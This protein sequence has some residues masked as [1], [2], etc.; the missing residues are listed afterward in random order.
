MCLCFLALMAYSNGFND[1]SCMQMNTKILRMGCSE[2]E[3]Q[4]PTKTEPYFVFYCQVNNTGI[5]II[6]SF[7]ANHKKTYF[8]MLAS[9]SVL[10]IF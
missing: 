8:L 10:K 2:S 5:K 3:V 6:C 1:L 7:T 9:Y 4:M